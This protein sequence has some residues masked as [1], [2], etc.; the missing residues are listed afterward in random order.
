MTWTNDG[1]V[2]ELIID[3]ILQSSL[4]GI[5]ADGII[6]ARS[7]F[8]VGGSD[9][10]KKN[11]E[12]V[13]H[14]LNVWDKVLWD[15]MLYMMTSQPGSDM[16]NFVAWRDFKKPASIP[17]ENFHIQK[18]NSNNFRV[19]TLVVAVGPKAEWQLRCGCN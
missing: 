18:D 17:D 8:I 16:G 9:V 6:S 11:L 15:E 10:E 19:Q 7:R 4:T 3:G 13:L 14:N 5:E 1:G 2:F 12:V